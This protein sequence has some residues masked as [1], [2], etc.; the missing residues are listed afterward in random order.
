MNKK[1]F[2]ILKQHNFNYDFKK[3]YS[4]MM[5]GLVL[6][7]QFL[8]K[9]KEGYTK[10]DIQEVKDSCKNAEIAAHDELKRRLYLKLK[11]E[12]INTSVIIPHDKLEKLFYEFFEVSGDFMIEIKLK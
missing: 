5:P 7:N 6:V 12:L 2:N 1:Q 10:E 8:A 9:H 3:N 4:C 11:K